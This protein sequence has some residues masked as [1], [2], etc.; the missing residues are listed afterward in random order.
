MDDDRVTCEI[1]MEKYDNANHIPK[2][3]PCCNNNFCI[4]CLKDI[5]KRNK[6]SILCPICR[7]STKIF[8]SNLPTDDSVLA[9][10]LSCLNC[11][12]PIIKSEI[13]ISL[14]SRNLSCVNCANNDM[15][16]NDFLEYIA[17]DLN[18]FIK[19]YSTKN[20]EDF[21]QRIQ[22][23]I[24]AKLNSLFTPLIQELANELS[25][26]IV[27]DIEMKY[28]YN[29]D[30]D[31]KKYMKYINELQRVT[32]NIDSFIRGTQAK[33]KLSQLQN[34]IQY[35]TQNFD[36]IKNER[37]LFDNINNFIKT[38]ELVK[39]KINDIDMKKFLV[40]IIEPE[41]ANGLHNG[42]TNI[43][44]ID[45]FDKQ[46]IPFKE[47]IS[48]LEQDNKDL[49]NQIQKLINNANNNNDN[50]RKDGTKKRG[51]NE[52]SQILLH[53][54]HTSNQIKDFVVVSTDSNISS[55]DF[56]IYDSDKVRRIDIYE[57]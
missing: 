7:K 22:S 21:K 16:L 54:S 34:D 1:C 18:D 23:K 37:T 42:S 48:K 41:N 29:I 11:K 50:K 57:D 28:H 40:H 17:G 49:E 5:Y 10:F 6:N 27:K 46:L 24:S 14:N 52:Q 53:S 9:D 4:S 25:N 32:T 31:F 45:F 26:K 51:T 2:Q 44:A 36:E 15:N 35:Y 19:E 20:E 13:N 47:K 56:G 39:I 55:Y 38:K 43:F 30:K 3:V 12:K 33:V 8:P